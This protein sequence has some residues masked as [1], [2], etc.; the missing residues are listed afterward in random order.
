MQSPQTFSDM[1]CDRDFTKGWKRGELHSQQHVQH[2]VLCVCV[3]SSGQ[4]KQL[5]CRNVTFAMSSLSCFQTCQEQ[6]P[7]WTDNCCGRM[8]PAAGESEQL[9]C[10]WRYCIPCNILKCCT[11]KR[12]LRSGCFWAGKQAVDD[13]SPLIWS[14]GGKVGR[15][16][17]TALQDY[18]WTCLSSIYS[19]NKSL[20]FLIIPWRCALRSLRAST[21]LDTAPPARLNSTHR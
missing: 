18:P 3:Q 1:V 19:R 5:L 6:V 2:H 15:C 7:H 20:L 16:H 4:G 13:L 17:I 21:R 11:K 9:Q 10:I 14:L 8:P 12:A